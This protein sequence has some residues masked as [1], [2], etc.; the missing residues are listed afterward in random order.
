MSAVASIREGAG[1]VPIAF[2]NR[3]GLRL[4]GILHMPAPEVRRSVG[5][6][7]LSPGVKMRVGPQCLYRRMTDRFV[8]LGFPV[9]RFDFYGLG[10]SEGE[11]TEVAL[12]DVYNHIE[13]GRFVDDTLDGLDWMERHCGLSRFV[14][15]GLCGGAITG[16]LAAGRDPRIAG[17][18]SLGITPVLASRAANPG[19][20][21]T[22]GQLHDLRRGYLRKLIDPMSWWRLLTLR[23][24]YD[25]IW[26]TLF[27]PLKRAFRK[28]AAV[29]AT[30]TAAP[31]ADDNANPL[32]PP[33]FFHMIDT[34]RP[35]LLVFSGGDRLYWE[36]QEKFEARYV[37]RLK[38]AHAGYKVHV[39]PNA[40]HVLS[41]PEWED[42]MLRVAQQWLDEKFPRTSPPGH[43]RTDIAATR[44]RAA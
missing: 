42:D 3:Q 9:F 44:T 40:N 18:L 16:L 29:T 13:V 4:Y 21:M 33:A 17:L 41:L 10:D 22:T 15:S 24:E 14:V 37:E 32:F 38:A 2:T 27:E 1:Q 6:V 35:M 20:Y 28:R 12:A 25:L 34:D 5:I 7:L 8:R 36:F 11:L 30:A 23:S 19:A 39:V 31:A 26:T 43:G